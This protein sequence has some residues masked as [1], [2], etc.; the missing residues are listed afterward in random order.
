MK[1]LLQ[2]LYLIVLGHKKS[3][4]KINIKALYCILYCIVLFSVVLISLEL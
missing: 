4:S 2:S 1:V 3:G